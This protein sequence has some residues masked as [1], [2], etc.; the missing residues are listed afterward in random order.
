[1]IQMGMR[2][3]NALNALSREGQIRPVQQAKL[4]ESLKQ[5]AVDQYPRAVGLKQ[6]FG[7]GNRLRGSM[8]GNATSTHGAS[9][10][11]SP[12]CRS[13]DRALS[14]IRTSLPK[15]SST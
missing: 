1:M 4:L 15:H 8:E 12:E 5:P 13:R 2:E 10:L 7:S 14:M 9:F 3:K 11:E 6:V